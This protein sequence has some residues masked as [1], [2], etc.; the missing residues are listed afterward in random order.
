MIELGSLEEVRGKGMVFLFI[1]ATQQKK[2]KVFKVVSPLFY[3]KR[4]DG[5]CFGGNAIS[6]CN[7]TSN[8]LTLRMFDSV[9]YCSNY[10]MVTKLGEIYEY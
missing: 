1:C 8:P 2:Q 3:M 9:N 7:S 6:F 4:C 10:K 5:F